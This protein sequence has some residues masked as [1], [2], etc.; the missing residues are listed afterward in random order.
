MTRPA[1]IAAAGWPAWSAVSS[2]LRAYNSTLLYED[3][4]YIVYW[5]A[6][7]ELILSYHILRVGL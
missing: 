7:K 2:M 6:V 4:R 3:R 1:Y 5:V